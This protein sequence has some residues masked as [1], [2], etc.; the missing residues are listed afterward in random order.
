VLIILA[1]L[2]TA[3]VFDRLGWGGGTATKVI[4]LI[5]VTALTVGGGV[6]GFDLIMRMQAVITVVTGVLTVMF[7][8]LVIDKIHWHTAAAIPGRLRREDHRCA[9]VHDDRLRPGLGQRRR[10]L[11][12]LPPPEVIKRR[13]DR[14]DDLRL[15]GGADLPVHFRAAAGRLVGQTER[16]EGFLITLGVP[17]AAWCGVMLA[18]IMLRRADYSEPDLY[19]PAGRYGDIRVLPL[20]VIVG[21][22]ILGWVSSPTPPRAGCPGRAICSSHSTWAGRPA[23]G[24]RALRAG[25][26]RRPGHADAVAAQEPDHDQVRQPDRHLRGRSR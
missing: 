16:G 15:V 12:A 3:T 9:G 24:R 1:T 18:D 25:H 23:R 8:V 11:L 2:A 10:G 19:A 6:I 14:L 5:V 13:R 22:T 7:I 4:A 20:T 21:S 26:R 17:I